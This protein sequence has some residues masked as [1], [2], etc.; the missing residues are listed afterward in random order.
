MPAKKQITKDMILHSALQLLKKSGMEAVNIK[1]LAKELH[2]STQPVY[3][4]FKSMDELRNEL[5]P[6]AVKEFEDMIKKQNKDGQIRL[7]GMEYIYFAKKEP[8]LF[9]FLFMRPNAFAEMKRML[10]PIIEQSISELMETYRISHEEAD[11]LHDHLWMHT[12]GIAS[13]IATDYCD[14]DLE[15]AERMVAECKTAFT[16]KFEA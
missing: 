9:C 1:A 14:W 4:S 6:V 15:K 3:L 7:Y 10:L 13:M 16:E 12:H 11:I 8:N 5:I 2:C